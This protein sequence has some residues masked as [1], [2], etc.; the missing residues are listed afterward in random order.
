M[1][2]GTGWLLR[3][4]PAYGLAIRAAADL[5]EAGTELSEGDI[6]VLA[7]IAYHQPI[8]RDEL[9]EVFGREISRDLI[10]RLSARDLI[11][12]GPRSP[13]RGAPYTCVTT[14][15]FRARFGLATLDDL[16]DPGEVQDA[17]LDP[18]TDRRDAE[19]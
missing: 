3:T 15:A 18:S 11:A 16:P 12:P 9:K 14:D 2:I 5:P 17:G 10:G 1:R 7:T 6:A 4:R 13:K 8:T 19:Q